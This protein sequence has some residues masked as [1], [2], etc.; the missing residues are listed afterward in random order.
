MP[1][2]GDDKNRGAPIYRSARIAKVSEEVKTA[3]ALEACASCNT[4]AATR[5]ALQAQGVKNFSVGNL[6]ESYE[7]GSSS[8]AKLYSPTARQLLAKYLMGAHLCL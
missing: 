3:L 7:L 2:G 5:S 4:E 6:S 8:M 1:F